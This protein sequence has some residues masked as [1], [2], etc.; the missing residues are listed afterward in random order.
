MEF[1]FLS[2][3]FLRLNSWFEP[4]FFVLKINTMMWNKEIDPF[5]FYFEIMRI[6]C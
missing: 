6:E 2:S 4:F 1:F 5:N 3:S